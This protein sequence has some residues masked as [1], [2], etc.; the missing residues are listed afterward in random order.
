ML[1]DGVEVERAGPSTS[2]GVDDM[3]GHSQFLL[4]IYIGSPCF[5]TGQYSV[6]QL[7]CDREWKSCGQQRA[8]RGRTQ[9]PINGEKQLGARSLVRVPQDTG[10]RMRRSVQKALSCRELFAFALEAEYNQKLYARA[11]LE[12]W[13]LELFRLG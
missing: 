13:E 1:S 3:L 7:R 11:D 6:L 12:V 8:A 2:I 9:T 4:G 10:V 5:E